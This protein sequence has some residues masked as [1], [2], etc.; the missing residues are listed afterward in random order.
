VA[1]LR[2]KLTEAFFF[3][4]AQRRVAW[5]ERVVEVEAEGSDPLCFWL[6]PLI[7]ARE[8]ECPKI[9]TIRIEGLTEEEAKVTVRKGELIPV[10]GGG[11]NVKLRMAGIRVIR[12]RGSLTRGE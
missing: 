1:N 11:L 3:Q 5:V 7:S 10:Q 4:N 6:Y 9:G 12:T 8:C 2:C